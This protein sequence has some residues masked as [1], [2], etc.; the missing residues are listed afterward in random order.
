MRKHIFLILVLVITCG[1]NEE[2]LSEATTTTV[3]NTNTT[4]APSTTTTT[5]IAPTTSTS[6]T[7]TTSTTTTTIAPVSSRCIDSSNDQPFYLPEMLSIELLS[8]KEIGP[9]DLIKVRVLLK[10]GTY[11]IIDF[12]IFAID[13]YGKRDSI[14]G[15]YQSSDEFKDGEFYFNS[16][17]EAFKGSRYNIGE[18]KIYSVTVTD[19]KG[20]YIYY[21]YDQI[22]LVPDLGC[23]EKNELFNGD[24]T[25][26]VIKES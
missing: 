10:K 20:N 17:Y 15:S 16:T 14:A 6:S 5:T 7:T 1:G 12:V 21:R 26:I 18:L 4:L 11:D 23:P 9:D 24:E 22:F 8:P 19:E 25:F 3:Q 13:S 2:S